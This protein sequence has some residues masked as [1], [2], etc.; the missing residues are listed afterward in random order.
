MRKPTGR[1]AVG[2]MRRAEK[3]TI[4]NLGLQKRGVSAQRAAQV[5]AIHVFT[6][7]PG[8]VA[9]DHRIVKFICRCSARI[10]K[11]TPTSNVPTKNRLIQIVREGTVTAIRSTARRCLEL[12][13]FFLS[14]YRP[15]SFFSTKNNKFMP[16]SKV[17]RTLEFV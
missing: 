10:N 11:I 8:C 5:G 6:R 3:Q 12:V 9:G 14:K 4:L 7:A 16:I 2:A 17:P 1:D 15:T 13:P